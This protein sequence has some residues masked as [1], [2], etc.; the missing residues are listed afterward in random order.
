MKTALATS[1]L[2][3]QRGAKEHNPRDNC[4]V[5]NLDLTHVVSDSLLFSEGI[6]AP[7]L[8]GTRTSLPV[9]QGRHS[10]LGR[11]FSRP[12]ELDV[13]SIHTPTGSPSL[14]F[15]IKYGGTAMGAHLSDARRR[16]D[17]QTSR[18][19]CSH[20]SR[21]PISF[22]VPGIASRG[23]RG[24]RVGLTFVRWTPPCC[25]DPKAQL[26]RISGIQAF[27]AWQK[28]DRKFRDLY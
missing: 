18:L 16:S 25:A 20:S 23:C 19:D 21:V 26:H 10:I 8:A 7:G 6:N 13:I 12:L 14:G 5:F 4:G 27:F 17:I 3:K 11:S 1:L 2:E 28:M 22:A 9:R 24:K 15:S